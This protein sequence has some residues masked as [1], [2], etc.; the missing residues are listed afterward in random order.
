MTSFPTDYER[1]DADIQNLRELEQTFRP[2]IRRMDEEAA[3][4]V[5]YEADIDRFLADIKKLGQLAE[6]LEAANHRL[7]QKRAQI[8]RQTAASKAEKEACLIPLE[9]DEQRRFEEENAAME[10]VVA[11]LEDG[12]VILETVSLLSQCATEFPLVAIRA[13]PA[14]SG[15]ME[16]P[17][18]PASVWTSDEL[19]LD[20]RVPVVFPCCCLD[21]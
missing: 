14:S 21:G 10:A 8:I 3:L 7:D 1:F 6:D 12:V 17:S 2:E 4:E 18:L 9:T 11:M 15:W 16:R 5:I 20:E 19:G 13:Y